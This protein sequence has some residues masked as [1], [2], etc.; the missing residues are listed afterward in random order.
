MNMCPLLPRSPYRSTGS[1]RSA[2]VLSLCSWV[3][4]GNVWAQANHKLSGPLLSPP[5]QVN[6]VSKFA[7]SP[8]ASRVV[9]TV[10]VPIGGVDD[11]LWSVPL[12]GSAVPVQL[13]EPGSRI[14]D[15]LQIGYRISPDSTRVVFASDPDVQY[16]LELFSAPI[17]G[18]AGPVQISGQMVANGDVGDSFQLTPD[19]TRVVYEA[20]QDTDGLIELYSAP[21]DGRSAP[22]K[23]NGPLPV[24]HFVRQFEISPDSSRVVYSLAEISTHETDQLFSV[25]LDGSASPVQ[26]NPSGRVRSTYGGSKPF[27]IC[28]DSSRVVYTADQDTT[29]V[30]E[31]YSAPIA[32]GSTVRLND[33]LASGFV[34]LDRISPDGPRAVYL[35][36]Y[37]YS[38]SALLSVAADGSASP[39]KLSG[40]LEAA[41]L[42]EL[43]PD[44]S[45][46]VFRAY[47][48]SDEIELFAAPIDGSAGPLQLN[49][50]L[51][52][53]AEVGLFRVS[54]DGARVVY[55][56]DDLHSVPIDASATLVT[57]NDASVPN[58]GIPDFEISADSSRVMFRAG[59]FFSSFPFPYDFYSVPIDGSSSPSKLNDS[60]PCGGSVYSFQLGP[61]GSRAVYLADQELEDVVELF[62]VPV[63]GASNPTKLNSLLGP[64][65]T[66]GDVQDFDTSPDGRR[67]VYR[68]DHDRADL[69]ELFSVRP[70]GSS[71]V[72]LTAGMLNACGDVLSLA[73]SPDSTQVVY[74]ADQHDQGF[75]QVEIFSVPIDGSANP[76]QLNGLLPY[77]GN[78]WYSG[79]GTG[80]RISPDGNWVVFSAS[81]F[82]YDRWELLSAPIDGSAPPVLLNPPL[83]GARDI[84]DVT[85]HPDFAISP[86]SSRVVYVGAQDADGVF[87]LY[88]VPIDGSSMPVKLNGALVAGGDVQGV[89]ARI[90]GVL[91]PVGFAFRISPDGTRV[92]YR[93]DQTADEIFQLFSVPIDAGASPTAISGPLVDFSDVLTFDVDPQ[94][95]HVLYRADQ[96]TNSRVELYSTPIDGS[97]S[98]VKL[99]PAL[100]SG[101]NVLE[102]QIAPDG[103]RAAYRAD[104]DVDNVP[105]LYGVPLDGSA[106]AVQ[107]NGALVAGGSVQDFRVSPDG[108]R[109]V[110]RAD[111]DVE[112]RREL[113]SAP[114][115]GSAGPVK[116]N[117][118]LFGP[119][120][121]WD[122]DGFPFPALAGRWVAYRA[123]QEADGRPELQLYRVPIDGSADPV[124]LSGALPA[125]GAITSA[126]IALHGAFVVY[127]AD[128]DTL[129]VTELYAT[130][131]G[132]APRTRPSS[133][134]TQTVIR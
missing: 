13:N 4:A 132:N 65:A 115:D 6:D 27:V 9:Y 35:V 128:Q 12:D 82:E 69:I 19:S 29:D 111:Q 44:G 46:V 16:E 120:V 87:E 101:G 83:S 105:E 125:G 57:L 130:A 45:Q 15:E 68:A 60:L 119:D 63:D 51:V 62:S 78:V 134:P 32:G 18:S 112:D 3:F 76:V 64:L 106:G 39:V 38:S 131:W 90:G 95:T 102:F 33:P 96:D 91:T 114:I 30:F 14:L 103:N 21:I 2:C 7:I 126:A 109:V 52:A 71:R 34:Y 89:A 124:K 41:P 43:S 117:D 74:L 121:T 26:L 28:P 70:D 40:T 116:L 49:G 22:V 72:N 123:D 73:I 129:N 77:L 100:V 36:D 122:V 53:G 8:D 84:L 79:G 56:A 20:D 67:V 42:V 25:P 85:G 127:A 17:D 88:S 5:V 133:T 92:V 24:N 23:L 93:A 48:G 10:R 47:D 98:P 31:L 97:S 37:P 58:E 80:Y 113:Y 86:D 50:P 81:P 107:L 1:S 94:G 11:E 108:A 75:G 110:Y 55:L 118:P 61:V 66:D 59:L 104:Q 99:N 54:P